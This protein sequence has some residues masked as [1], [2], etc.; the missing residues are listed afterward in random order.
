[1]AVQKLCAVLGE[2][3]KNINDDIASLVKKGLSVQIQEA[4]DI[5]RVIGNEAV[6]P[7]QIDLNDDRATA[8][9]LF[10]LVNLIIEERI[11]EPKRR[12]EMYAKLPASKRDAIAK[13]DGVAK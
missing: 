8:A 9:S 10:E 4:L 12:A 1:L 11:S 2:S 3:G 6:H 13:R 5:V 7:G